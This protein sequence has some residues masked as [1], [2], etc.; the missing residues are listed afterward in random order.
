MNDY[1]TNT[2]DQGTYGAT[3]TTAFATLMRNV[4][5]W[6]CLALVITGM[7]AYMVGHSFTLQQVILGNPIVFYGLMIGELVL[8]VWLS[9][10]LQKLSLTTAGIMF[11][12]YSIINGLTLG[13]VFLVYTEA[14]IAQAFFI[15]AGTFGGMSLL[16]YTTKKDLSTI[17]RI[18]YMALIGL[19][20]AIVVNIFLGSSMFDLVISIFGLIIFIGLTAWDTQK[21]KEMLVQAQQ[22]GVTEETSKIALIGSLELYLD[23]INI[24][25]YILRLFGNRR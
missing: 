21:I 22:Y 9:A 14:S 17:G 20:I 3:Q 1:K 13:V 24:F 12:A 2:Y 6:M 18:C 15:S 8:V 23:F 25:L 4:Y 5:S 10:R 16:G 7:C 11:G 19:I